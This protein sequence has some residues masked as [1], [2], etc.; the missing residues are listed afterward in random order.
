MS[1]EIN[2]LAKNGQSSS[3]HNDLVVKDGFG[4]EVAPSGPRVDAGS[5]ARN[6]KTGTLSPHVCGQLEA[7]V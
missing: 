6:E 1:A 5:L 7:N 2:A 3:E 4:F